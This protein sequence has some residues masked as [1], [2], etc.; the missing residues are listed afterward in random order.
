MAKMMRSRSWVRVSNT[1]SADYS[2]SFRGRDRREHEA[3]VAE[4]ADEID[5]DRKIRE[6]WCYF[7]DVYTPEFADHV[8][9]MYGLPKPPS[10]ERRMP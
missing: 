3:L 2:G 10:R 9:D 7:Y 4:W 8:L 1:Y 6:M 5:E